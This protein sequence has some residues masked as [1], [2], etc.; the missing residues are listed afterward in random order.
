MLNKIITVALVAVLAALLLPAK[1]G[2]WGAGRASYTQVGPDGG[3]Y[4]TDRAIVGGPGGVVAGSRT[5]VAGP[6]GVVAASRTTVVGAGGGGYRYSYAHAGGIG[7][8]GVGAGHIRQREGL[9]GPWLSQGG[10]PCEVRRE[11]DSYVFINDQGSWA[12]FVFASDIRLEQVDGQWDRN[13]TCTVTR[14]ELGRITL[15]FDSPNAASG[16]WTPAD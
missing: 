10:A 14:D 16:Y 2:A 11:G 6:G 9:S 13:V 1:V 12:R 5:T 15:R 7:I 4:Q 8:G 3:V